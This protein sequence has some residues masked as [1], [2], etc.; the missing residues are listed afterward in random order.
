M[1]K[2]ELLHQVK[3]AK[4]WFEYVVSNM[5]RD[6]VEYEGGFLL[7][8]N[9]IILRNED[10]LIAKNIEDVIN[11][12]G[13]SLLSSKNIYKNQKIALN[14]LYFLKK[15]GVAIQVDSDLWMHLN[16]YKI[17]KNKLILH[18]SRNVKLSVLELKEAISVTRKNAI[19]ILEFCDKKKLNKRID[20]HRIMGDCLNE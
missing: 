5:K 16:S 15:E 9:E 8:N 11:K 12:T 14:L 20:N 17:L 7:K 19:P 18:F 3:F 6:V 1:S 2:E 13:F 4:E 10:T